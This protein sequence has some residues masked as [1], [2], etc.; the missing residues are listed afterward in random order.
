MSKGEHQLKLTLAFDYFLE[1][2]KNYL[3]DNNNPINIKR[4]RKQK[5]KEFKQ[6]FISYK[7]GNNFN[8]ATEILQFDS[9]NLCV[10][11][12]FVVDAEFIL[13]LYEKAIE[14]VIWEF[15]LEED[16]P[17]V[18]KSQFKSF[19]MR[20]KELTN[21]LNENAEINI[22]KSELLSGY[23]KTVAKVERVAEMLSGFK[24]T[25]KVKN[26]AVETE[27]CVAN[28]IEFEKFKGNKKKS[29]EKGMENF[30]KWLA[31]KGRSTKDDQDNQESNFPEKGEVKRTS[32]KPQV[33][34]HNTEDVF[35]LSLELDGPNSHFSTCH[36]TKLE[37]ILKL[38]GKEKEKKIE[39]LSIP[40]TRMPIKST[41]LNSHGNALRVLAQITAQTLAANLLK[42]YGN[43][44]ET[45]GQIKGKKTGPS[46]HHFDLPEKHVMGSKYN[47]YR[48]KSALS[49]VHSTPMTYVR[50][51]PSPHHCEH[52]FTMLQR[53]SKANS[54]A[55]KSYISK[56]SKKSV[57]VKK[58]QK[59]EPNTR[60]KV[61]GKYL[62]KE[63]EEKELNEEDKDIYIATKKKHMK[64][65]GPS[66]SST[67][68]SKTLN[69]NKN[70][71]KYS[72]KEISGVDDEE[73]STYVNDKKIVENLEK[74]WKE[75][76]LNLLDSLENFKNAELIKPKTAKSEI[77]PRS[78][79]P[80]D[81][82]LK[83]K[84]KA[85]RKNEYDNV[86][87]R[88]DFN[89]INKKHHP[90]IKK[91]R[92]LNAV[93][94]GR[95]IIDVTDFFLGEID[96]QSDSGG[97]EGIE[98]LK[99]NVGLDTPLFSDDQIELLNPMCIYVNSIDGMPNTPIS[100]EELDKKCAP[101]YSS[102]KFFDEFFEYISKPEVPSRKP[103][104]NFYSKHVVLPGLMEEET[105]YNLFLNRK[106]EF[107]IHDRDIKIDDELINNSI[108]DVNIDKKNSFGVASF[109][110]MI[111]GATD[112]NL[113]IPILPPRNNDGPYH[114]PPG[115]WLEAHS[116]LNIRVKIKKPLFQNLKLSAKKPLEN[117]EEFNDLIQNNIIPVTKSLENL[118]NA[119]NNSLVLQQHPL[120]RM[121]LFLSVKDNEMFNL[122]QN[123]VSENNCK[124]LFQN[125]SE[126][127]LLSYYRLSPEQRMSNSLDILTGYDIND[128]DYRIM[129]IEGI[130]E[131]GVEVLSKF[132]TGLIA[133]R[134]D[135]PLIDKPML[136]FD[137]LNLEKKRNWIG[138]L[139]NLIHIKLKSNLHSLMSKSSTYL[140][141]NLSKDCF[142]CLNILHQLVLAATKKNHLLTNYEGK[143]LANGQHCPTNSMIN[144]LLFQFGEL[145]DSSHF[146]EIVSSEKSPNDIGNF[147]EI[148]ISGT[149]N[150]RQ[151][152]KVEDLSKF[153]PERKETKK[154]L[155]VL[156]KNK[157]KIF[158]KVDDK[159][160]KFVQ[161]IK[162]THGLVQPNFIEI[163]NSKFNKFEKK[164]NFYKRSKSYNKIHNYSIQELSSTC[165]QMHQLR[166]KISKDPR[167][168]YAYGDRFFS[169]TVAPVDV[170]EEE[171][172]QEMMSRSKWQTVHGFKR[173]TNLNSDK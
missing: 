170:I 55:G 135:N 161:K 12:D 148:N 152:K 126:F 93:E 90:L 71:K 128:E 116:S 31:F 110:E 84:K 4:T 10:V 144:A 115:N 136:F 81:D 167:H 73:N 101:P 140:K 141:K 22:K 172:R 68:N 83:K 69:K 58:I 127:N 124:A 157:L 103:V 72:V 86:L 52:P 117:P 120:S 80:V 79:E 155:A 14:V 132:I 75:D 62:V 2:K 78:T 65:S 162:Y 133:S 153:N 11:N 54:V 95:V 21:G 94:V 6:F 57:V 8:G 1:P 64:G 85:V 45:L 163:Y 66:K 138:L 35:Q 38:K 56:N 5:E 61:F 100:Y 166:H 30:D 19:L 165:E 105:L 131:K 23:K 122:I 51:E 104:I 125:E 43:A 28:N 156:N 92:L 112:L 42:N 60:K 119:K 39:P 151:V 88:I 108:G 18:T 41:N 17:L 32:T 146:Q 44:T 164:E 25:P 3:D 109:S 114:L 99:V 36:Q 154:I 111:L 121:F 134:P 106:L 89:D 139:P 158:K 27:C 102:F 16:E 33:P 37:N 130:R 53:G 169:Q 173:N 74:Q 137:P 96:V 145:V 123:F 149:E 98:S 87:K 20:N 47:L 97:V 59:K 129:L 168:F 26:D 76:K 91:K 24:E 67:N 29:K 40:E 143:L 160:L 46:P 77:L 113:S 15:K 63:T 9:T 7:I 171:K 49:L 34:V 142:D 48:S 118:K 13:G 107:K 50:Q 70:K 150:T 147:S 82:I 159:N